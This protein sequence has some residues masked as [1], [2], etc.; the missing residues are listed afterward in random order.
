MQGAFERR[1]ANGSGGLSILFRLLC[2][3]TSSHF[4]SMLN[5]SHRCKRIELRWC[6]HR[7]RTIR[8]HQ[9]RLKY[10]RGATN[11]PNDEKRISKEVTF[12]VKVHTRFLHSIIATGLGRGGSDIGTKMRSV[13]RSLDIPVLMSALQATLVCSQRKQTPPP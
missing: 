13:W 11:D 7:N 6:H 12:S 4:R 9:G 3:H 5:T 2:V 10:D 8:R 1:G